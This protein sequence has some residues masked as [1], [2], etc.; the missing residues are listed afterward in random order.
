MGGVGA[1]AVLVSSVRHGVVGRSRC[2]A[3][4]SMQRLLVGGTT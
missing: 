1:R 3:S 4:F 2:L